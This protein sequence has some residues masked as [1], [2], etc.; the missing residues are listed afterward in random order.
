MSL[1]AALCS[2][3]VLGAS[4]AGS[5]WWA[6]ERGRDAELATQV[7]EQQVAAAAT[8]AAASAAA[9]A[10]A[11]IKVQHKTVQQEVQREIQE[12][13]VYRDP[14]CSHS[15]EQLQRI[16]AALTGAPRPEP[17]SRGLVPRADAALGPVFRRDDAQADRGGGAVP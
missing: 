2:L 5:L 10:V 14:A 1:Y 6:Y 8:Q 7:R 16:N 12:R 13:V 4:W 17:A 9:A 11:K 3:L 15:P